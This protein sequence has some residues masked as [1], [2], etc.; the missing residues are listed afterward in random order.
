MR[1]IANS[2]PK[3]GTHLLVRFLELLGLNQG[4][5]HLSASLVRLTEKNPIRRQLKKRQ[6]WKEGMPGKG[7]MVDLDDPENMIKEE[8]FR[9]KLEAVNDNSFLQAHL[10]YSQALESLLLSL[11]YKI[12]YIVRDPRD[13]AISYCNYVLSLH[14]H[15]FHQFFKKLDSIQNNISLVLKGSQALNGQNLAPFGV[16][17]Q[18]SLGWFQSSKVCGLR[19]EELVGKQ[20][21]GSDD[22]QYKKVEAIC[23]YLGANLSTDDMHTL[24]SKLFY[25]KAKTFNKGKIGTWKDV[26]DLEMRKLFKKYCGQSLIELGYEKNHEW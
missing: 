25:P 21:N 10:P 19:F 14:T 6:L 2:L 9:K 1:V 22:I 20:G 26:L 8:W 11:D 3:S 23:S 24:A 12:L 18:N 16:S 4:D 5:L 7:I 17:I 13:V 15:P